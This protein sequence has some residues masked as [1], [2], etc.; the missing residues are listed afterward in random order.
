MRTLGKTLI[1]ANNHSLV[2][3]SC[4]I[5]SGLPENSLNSIA[6]IAIQ[7]CYDSG[8]FLMQENDPCHGFFLVISGRVRVYKSSVNG[9]EKV[10]LIAEKSMTFGEDGLF[11]EGKYFATAVAMEKTKILFIPREYFLKI[12]SENLELSLQIME[13]LTMWIKRLSTSV[14]SFAL[15]SAQDKTSQYLSGLSKKFGSTTFQLPYKKK[16]IADHLNIAPETFSR[17]LHE[18]V[19][20]GIISLDQRIITIHRSDLL[21]NIN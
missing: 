21:E 6:S 20:K 8:Q 18:L 11:G 1:A 16:Q 17:S 12:L 13:S 3:A 7:R 10:L 2:S 4:P 9:K 14:E 5:C 15:M 19:E